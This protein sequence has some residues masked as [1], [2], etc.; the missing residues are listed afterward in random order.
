MMKQMTTRVIWN[1]PIFCESMMRERST[2]C[3]CATDAPPLWATSCRLPRPLF[4]GTRNARA[5]HLLPTFGWD[6]R[7]SLVG[8]IF[9]AEP[10]STSA[11]NALRQEAGRLDLRFARELRRVPPAAQRLDEIDARDI[12]ALHDGERR[13]L[14]RQRIRLRR[15]DRG[16]VDRSGAVLV[17]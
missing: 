13:L 14:A 4:R 5:T 10:A 17:E 8:R 9:W 7:A 16:V 6:I 12:A 2:V 3:A 11:E 1:A 15:D